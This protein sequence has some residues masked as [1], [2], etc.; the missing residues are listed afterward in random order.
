MH[1]ILFEMFVGDNEDLFVCLFVHRR[2][3]RSR[4]EGERREEEAMMMMMLMMVQS[5]ERKSKRK[6]I[7]RTEGRISTKH[8]INVRHV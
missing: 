6:G 3:Q 2:W 8:E 4:K 7:I 1:T 5:E